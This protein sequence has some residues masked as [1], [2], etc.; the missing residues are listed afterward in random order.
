M[1]EK[2]LTPAQ[3]TIKEAFR[4]AQ[5]NC[6]GKLQL[7]VAINTTA[8]W[9]YTCINRGTVPLKMAMKLEVLTRGEVK[10]ADI[11]VKDI[12]EI[13]AVSKYLK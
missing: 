1:S 8:S 4:L 2:Q 5:I 13:N 6:G 12:T 3:I 9:I 7:Q 10:A 11:A